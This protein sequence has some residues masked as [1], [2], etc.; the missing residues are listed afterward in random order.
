[1]AWTAYWNPV[2]ETLSGSQLRQLQLAKFKRQVDYVF[3]GS[4]FYRQKLQQAGL[5][6]ADIRSLQDVEKIPLTTKDELQTAQETGSFPYG[7]CLTVPNEDV[8]AYHQTSGTTGNPIKQADSRRDWEWWSECW[9]TLLWAQGF[10]PNERVFFPFSYGV[11]VAFWAAHY[12]CEKIGCEVVPGGGIST[13]DR[14]RKMQELKVTAVMCTPTYGLHMAET[15]E[16]MGIDLAKDLSVR[17][18]VCAGEPGASIPATKKRLQDYWGAKVYDHAGAT[19]GGAWGFECDAHSG[20]IHINEAFFLVEV[21]DPDSGEAVKPGEEGELVITPLDR[22]AQP[23]LR[24]A[25][26]DMA[27]LSHDPCPC[28]RSFARLKG[29]V[30]GRRDQLTKVRGVL[31]SPTCVEEIVHGLGQLGDEYQVIVEKRGQLDE[32][33]VKAELKEGA[34]SSEEL[35]KSLQQGLRLQTGLRCNVE[36]VETGTLPRFEVKAKRF[37]DL[38]RAS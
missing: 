9:A 20:D 28:G 7:A 36:L 8:I 22:Q 12:A 24:F 31:F 17:K 11:F 37:Q 34:R 33:T 18:M 26:R 6:P 13:Q 14:I 3:K 27:L 32:I 5:S 38:R 4:S 16:K 2:L 23:Y 29:G 19:E 15:A 35:E 30:L 1:M 10:R 21:L 25:L